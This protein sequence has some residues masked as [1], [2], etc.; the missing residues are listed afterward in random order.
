MTTRSA[1]DASDG[2]GGACACARERT[3]WP[4]VS[5]GG[6]GQ[7]HTAGWGPRRIV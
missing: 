6:L 4:R 1:G 3:R 7:C 5:Q 2:R